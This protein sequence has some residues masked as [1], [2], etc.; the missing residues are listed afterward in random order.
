MN[1]TRKETMQKHCY[2]YGAQMLRGFWYYEEKGP[3]L[4]LFFIA[5]TPSFLHLNILQL[6]RAVLCLTNDYFYI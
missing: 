2:F 3:L 4:T 5:F 6:W 1:T